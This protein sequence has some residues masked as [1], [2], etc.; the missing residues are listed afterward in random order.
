MKM[1]HRA[2]AFAIKSLDSKTG[3]FS[4]YGSVFDV[5]DTYQERIAPGAFTKTLSEWSAKGKL[6]PMLWQHFMSEPIGKWTKMDQDDKGLYA[7]GQVLVDA[8]ATERRAYEHM[9]AGTVDGLSIGFMIPSGG[10]SWDEKA[11]VGVIHEVDLWELSVVTIPAN[12]DARVDAIKAALAHPKDCERLLRDA[13]FSRSQAKALMAEGF[14]A[15][16]SQRDADDE[17]RLD[18]GAAEVAAAL[19]A[20]IKNTRTV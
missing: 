3:K 14:K 11:G 18:C 17:G 6:P 4:G 19:E 2:A 13:G 7:E 5:V 9:K 1:K 20:L 16:A 15:L 12:P 10:F 8:G